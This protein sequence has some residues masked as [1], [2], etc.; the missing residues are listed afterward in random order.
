[1]DFKDI[2]ELVRL[3]SEAQINEVKIEEGLFKLRIRGAAYQS[4]KGVQTFVQAPVSQPI[5]TQPV[6]SAPVTEAKPAA[7]APQPTV[8]TK[9]AAPGASGNYKEI[10][11]PM[12]GT[13]YRSAGP[14]KAPFVQVG[15]VVK[16][17]QP[18][19]IIEAMKLFNTLESEVAGKIVKILVD[20]ASPV[21]YDMP[22]F[23]VEPE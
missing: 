10:K 16:V 3:V 11:T 17:G 21:E 5:L 4:G 22:L 12:V 18:I 23:L 6:A 2:Q 13:F 1:M 20:D 19:C 14:D 8:E 15:D 9:P 7:V